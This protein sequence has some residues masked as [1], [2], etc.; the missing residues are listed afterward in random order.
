[1]GGSGVRRALSATTAARRTALQTTYY[2]KVFKKD[3]PR[4]I[5]ILSDIL[6]NSS[7]NVQA[8]ERE[9][10]VILREMQEVGTQME[11]VAFDHLHA[12]AYQ[13]TPLG[14]TILG[15]A[16]NV[17]R[18]NQRQLLDYIQTHYVAPRIV[19][20]AAGGVD[21][22]QLV[23]LAEKHF[24]KLKGDYNGVPVQPKCRFT[25]GE[26]RVRDDDMPLAYIA[27]AVEGVGHAHPDYFPLLIASTIV[28]SWDRTFGGGQNLSSRLA[29]TADEHQLA[30]SY[31]SFNTS[32]IDTSL[33]G[34]FFVCDRWKIE[35][36]TYAVQQEWMH[37]CT[38][39]TEA[40]VARARNQLK[41]STMLQLDGTTPIC[42]D[43]GRQMLIY[44]RRMPPAEF[45][46]R[47]DAVDANA[48]MRV[49]KKYIYDRCPAVAA[50]GP[51]EQLPDYNRIRGAQHWLRT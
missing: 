15:P 32:Y 11:E 41:T 8:I 19:M 25:G 9:R 47:I 34:I 21:H 50:I 30:N 35:D 39:V 36:M 44:G 42:E 51:I 1:M 13:G 48:V 3:I 5:D 23:E 33:W 24:S 10:S 26:M 12:V 38:S 4:A 45:D 20:A 14:R 2:A 28:G 27:M 49:G 18:I 43:I 22:A 40:E 6:Q 7:F 29:R 31:M 16:E 17:R 46:A 37:V